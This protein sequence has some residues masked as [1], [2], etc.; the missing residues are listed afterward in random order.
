MAGC[1]AGAGVVPGMLANFVL[2]LLRLANCY[3]VL[4][5]LQLANFVNQWLNS[6]FY[7]IF[8]ATSAYLEMVLVVYL[9]QLANVVNQWLNCLN[10]GIFKPHPHV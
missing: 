8:K 9:L 5:L 7:G 2:Y 6:L 4:Y 3:F 10:Y 1:W